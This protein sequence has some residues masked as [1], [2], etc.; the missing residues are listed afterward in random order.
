MVMK[1]KMIII[2]FYQKLKKGSEEKYHKIVSRKMCIKNLKHHY[3]ESK[4]IQ[5]LEK[6]GIGRPNIF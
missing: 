1:K 6:K 2:N 5:L 4:L 3:N